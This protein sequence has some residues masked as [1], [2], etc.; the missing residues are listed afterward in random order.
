MI[1]RVDVD[2]SYSFRCEVYRDSPANA[3]QSRRHFYL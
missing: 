3:W 2:H 1:P